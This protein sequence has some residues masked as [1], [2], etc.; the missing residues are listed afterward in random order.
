[1]HNS[2]RL[3]TRPMTGRGAAVFSPLSPP[4]LQRFT[5]FH[6]HGKISKRNGGIKSKIDMEEETGI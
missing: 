6:F 5:T 1:M 4:L 3:D 2:K